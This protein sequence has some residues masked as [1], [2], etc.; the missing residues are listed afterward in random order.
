M[1]FAD[2]QRSLAVLY[3]H[4]CGRT[5]YP[6]RYNGVCPVCESGNT[7]SGMFTPD[8]Q[9][10]VAANRA[11]RDMIPETAYIVLAGRFRG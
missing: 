3:C 10:D 2:H 6:M 9:A 1:T 8:N 4:A 11:L 7:V 5:I